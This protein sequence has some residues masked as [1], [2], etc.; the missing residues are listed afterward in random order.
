MW[1]LV[2]AVLAVGW[3]VLLVAAPVVP[4]AIAT[5][6]YAIGSLICHQRPERSFHIDAAQLPVCARCLGIYAGAA[7]GACV[8]LA[9]GTDVPV[10]ARTALIAGAVPTLAT[11]ALELTGVWAPGNI[12]RSVAGLPLGLAAA[13]VLVPRLRVHYWRDVVPE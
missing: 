8:R 5:V 11:I 7:I 12:A 4:T 3:L 6:A 1:S 13:F 2:L 10:T 9:P